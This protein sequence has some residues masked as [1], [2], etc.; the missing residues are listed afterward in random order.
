[1]GLEPKFAGSFHAFPENEH[2][3]KQWIGRINRKHY[4]WT[5]TH[6]VCSDH[7]LPSDFVISHEAAKNLGYQPGKF[8][9][10]ENVVPSIKLKGDANWQG[11]KE[12]RSLAVMRD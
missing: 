12:R 9:L 5:K 8:Q 2:L 10:K 3:R 1:M 6:R 7:F 4:T 11:S